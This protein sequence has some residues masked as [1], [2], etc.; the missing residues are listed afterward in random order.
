M[1]SARGLAGDGICTTFRVIPVYI[2]HPLHRCIVFVYARAAVCHV[3]RLRDV[4]IVAHPFVCLVS[5]TVP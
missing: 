3:Q 5:C 1:Q 4:R 2:A